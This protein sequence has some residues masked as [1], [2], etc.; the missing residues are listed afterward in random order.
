MVKYPKEKTIRGLPYDLVSTHGSKSTARVKVF[1]M[2][3]VRTTN[4]WG[5]TS[6]VSISTRIIKTKDGRWAIYV[7]ET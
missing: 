6:K 5:I 4:S 7:R 2:K 1:N 3:R